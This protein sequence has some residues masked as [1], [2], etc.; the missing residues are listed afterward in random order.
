MCFPLVVQSVLYSLC[1]HIVV[2]SITFEMGVG[3]SKLK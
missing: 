1:P 3:G 2:K